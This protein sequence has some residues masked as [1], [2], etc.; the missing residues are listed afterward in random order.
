MAE[1]MPTW[2]YPASRVAVIASILSFLYT[3][4]IVGRYVGI[5]SYSPDRLIMMGVGSASLCVVS[6][7]MFI[8]L[9]REY[10]NG[11]QATGAGEVS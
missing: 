9:Y 1:N 6:I 11:R 8:W 2:W 10:K 5:I 4:D 7:A 3:V